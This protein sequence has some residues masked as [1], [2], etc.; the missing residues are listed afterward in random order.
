[1]NHD[2]NTEEEYEQFSDGEIFIKIWTSPRKVFRFIHYH[3]YHKYVWPLLFLAGIARAFDRAILKNIG[4]QLPLSDILWGCITLGGLLGWLSYY[5]YAWLLSW[6]GK[7]LEGEANTTS[8]VRVLTYA[9]FPSII[10]LLVVA[11]QIQAFGIELF[12]EYGELSSTTLSEEILLYIAPILE[13]VLG[14][15]TLVL[16]TIAVSEA[17]QFSIGKA[18]LNLLLPVL[19]L[20]ALFIGIATIF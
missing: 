7:W 18:I 20:I 14:A 6:T 4:D 1:M 19:I 9:S 11:A 12:K 16:S 15:W 13:L 8:L 17:Q 10:A 3:E 5:L 2:L